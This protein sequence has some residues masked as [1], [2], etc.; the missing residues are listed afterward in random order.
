[1]AVRYAELGFYQAPHYQWVPHW[2]ESYY[3]LVRGLLQFVIYP[4]PDL[5]GDRKWH[6]G[7]PVPPITKTEN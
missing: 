4:Q 2:I 5:A 3:G 6:A 7:F 1:V